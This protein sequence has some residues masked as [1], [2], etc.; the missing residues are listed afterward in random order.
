MGRMVVSWMF[1][2]LPLGGAPSEAVTAG[3]ALALVA[4]PRA[5][6][7]SAQKKGCSS[8]LPE[9]VQVRVRGGG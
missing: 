4:P 9:G 2:A 8:G 6:V 5:G 7:G 3:A 1:A